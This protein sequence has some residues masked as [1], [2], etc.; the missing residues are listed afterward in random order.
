V[1]RSVLF[2]ISVQRLFPQNW[3][4]RLQWAPPRCPKWLAEAQ[5]GCVSKMSN[6]SWNKLALAAPP[7]DKH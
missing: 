5:K 3:V 2:L 4:A 1:A 6:D 7:K